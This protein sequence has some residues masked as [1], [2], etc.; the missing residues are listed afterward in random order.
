MGVDTS[1]DHV[2]VVAER[3]VARGRER[4]SGVA[5]G[6][7]RARRADEVAGRACGVGEVA[8]RSR[9]CG[10]LVD[11]VQVDTLCRSIHVR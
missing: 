3:V 8:G 2:E 4:A 10:D 1:G 6:G 7:R 11:S 9:V 5:V